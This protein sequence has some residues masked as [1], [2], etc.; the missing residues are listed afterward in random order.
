MAVGGFDP[1]KTLPIQIDTGTNNQKLLEDPYYLGLKEKRCDENQYYELF[2][3][4]IDV[5]SKMFPKTLFI[6]ENFE[7]K[8]GL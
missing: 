4:I 6:M 1:W 7:V 2:D 5:C 8:H 3:E